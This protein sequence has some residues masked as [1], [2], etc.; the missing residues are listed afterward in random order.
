MIWVEVE[1]GLDSY[2]YA[3]L[4]GL[5]CQDTDSEPWHV[6]VIN[7][8]AWFIL[9]LANESVFTLDQIDSF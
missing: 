9:Y 4:Q 6:N 5:Q 2:I 3:S 8:S 1:V 7:I